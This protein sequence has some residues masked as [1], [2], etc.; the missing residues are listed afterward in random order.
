MNTIKITIIINIYIK[1]HTNICV[2][3]FY[4][5]KLNMFSNY[6]TK[7]RTPS[8]LPCSSGPPGSI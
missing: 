7:I 1:K 5:C 3:M 6:F 8:F 2:R 4:E